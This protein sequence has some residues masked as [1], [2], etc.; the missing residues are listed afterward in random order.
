MD[1]PIEATIDSKTE[2]PPAYNDEFEVSDE[3]ISKQLELIDITS[4]KLSDTFQLMG[5]TN[6][7]DE[8]ILNIKNNYVELLND[9]RVIVK[10][11]AIIMQNY[12]NL[13]NIYDN[14][15]VILSTSNLK[16][17]FDK[18]LLMIKEEYNIKL[19][20]SQDQTAIILCEKYLNHLF[21]K[22]NT[23]LATYF[24]KKTVAIPTTPA[25]NI[26]YANGH[27]IFTDA[28][29]KQFQTQFKYSKELIN[30]T[31]LITTYFI[32]AQ[33]KTKKEVEI[34][35]EEVIDLV[36]N[37]DQEGI[38]KFEDIIKNL[39]INYQNNDRY[40]NFLYEQLYNERKNQVHYI[41]KEIFYPNC[42]KMWN[43]LT[44]DEK[45]KYN[46]ME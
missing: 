14:E 46:E 15:R 44:N 31:D 17:Y 36:L 21:D 8:L 25:L 18:Q 12:T 40:Y 5:L 24:N 30:M 3:D 22:G 29:C 10:E 7:C 42:V 11:F 28:H 32:H 33:N 41:Y 38:L 23:Q 37:D 16:I 35:Y 45:Q 27:G 9:S 2:S 13:K 19:L 20:H 6:E 26:G 4:T 1:I 43:N 34:M 39:D